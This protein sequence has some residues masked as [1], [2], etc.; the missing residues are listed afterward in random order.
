MIRTARSQR[1]HRRGGD[2]KCLRD[3]GGIA[4][5]QG[6]GSP[7]RVQRRAKQSSGGSTGKRRAL[8]TQSFSII[9][10]NGSSWVSVENVLP[11]LPSAI[12]CVQEHRLLPSR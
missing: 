10:I 5:E 6:P 8:S 1:L 9:T 7:G 11:R 4:E 2:S 12:I 3:T